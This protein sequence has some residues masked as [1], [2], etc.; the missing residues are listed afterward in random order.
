MKEIK[1]IKIYEGLGKIFSTNI[2]QGT[3]AVGIL[4]L[5]FT[6]SLVGSIVIAGATAYFIKKEETK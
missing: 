5:I 6:G 3:T 2:A 1:N 4:G